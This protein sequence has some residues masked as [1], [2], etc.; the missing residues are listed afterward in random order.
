MIDAMI[1][2]FNGT[3]IFDGLIQKRAWGKFLEIE[4]NRELTSQDYQL[5]IAGINNRNTFRVLFR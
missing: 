5:H 4:F 1:F 3:M 2:D